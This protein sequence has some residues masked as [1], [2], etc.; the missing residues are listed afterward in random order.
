[1]GASRYAVPADI[2][3]HL[4]V[5]SLD[6]F[7]PLSEGWHRFLGLV[8]VHSQLWEESLVTPARPSPVA[9]PP[10]RAIR[11]T[12]IYKR[13]GRQSWEVSSKK[14]RLRWRTW[15]DDVPGSASPSTTSFAS[16]SL[17]PASGRS[18]PAV[19]VAPSSGE[20]EVAMHRLFGDGPVGFHSRE[21]E[22]GMR[23]VLNAET[24]VT[25]V[26]PTGGGKTLLAMLPVVLET[27]G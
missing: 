22:E 10:A 3:K 5:R 8:S 6:T 26:L 14:Q 12:A 25:V 18:T 21:Q 17:P 23:A 24:P 20:I 11:Y 1:M 15:F 9:P 19:P 16:S 27:R 2:I 4:S 7:R 13:R